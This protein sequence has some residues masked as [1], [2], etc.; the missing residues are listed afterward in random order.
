MFST[1]NALLWAIF[2]PLARLVLRLR[3]NVTAPRCR[4]KAPYV[5]LCN[6]SSYYDPLLAAV[7]VDRPLRFC[8]SDRAPWRGFLLRLTR[9]LQLPEALTL[10]EALAEAA[11][12]KKCLGLFPEGTRC[13]DGVT[14][15]IPPDLGEKLLASGLGLVTLRIS[16]AYFTAPRWADDFPRRGRITVRTVRTLEPAMLQAL[17]AAELQ[18]LIERDLRE[19]A[20]ATAKKRPAPYRGEHLAAG[21]ERL[22]F[23]CPK[24]GAIG[25]MEGRER[26]F[27]CKGCG[28]ETV[29]TLTGG[30][31]GGGVPFADLR[32]WSRWQEGRIR[33]LCEAAGEGPI[34]EDEG[35]ELYVQQPGGAERV[36]SGGLQLYRD[37]LELP[38]GVAVAI[39]EIESLRLGGSSRLLLKSKR[40]SRFELDTVR[41]VCAAKYITA[42][43]ILKEIEKNR[44]QDHEQDRI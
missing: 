10:D 36:G 44:G 27:G 18:A 4:M 7:S 34:F 3:L 25:R 35:F 37:R 8:G 21:L 30:F 6:H 14:G 41:A 39:G 19:D 16:G 26:F 29:Y 42:L 24:C 20:C 28:F 40:G 23:L 33:L 1:P 43:D 31:R 12:R 2:R 5:L 11:A 15:P 9:W 17:D 38:T 32:E 13:I 22:L